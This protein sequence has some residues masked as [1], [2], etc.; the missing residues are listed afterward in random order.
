MLIILFNVFFLFII[1]NHFFYGCIENFSDDKYEEYELS[2]SSNNDILKNNKTSLSTLKSKFKKI[3]NLINNNIK[4]IKQNT[5]NN[6]DS[7][8]ALK[9]DDT[10]TSNACEKYPQA[11]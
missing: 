4:Q 2:I 10:D 11:C 9:G 8:K 5:K 6:N 3:S 1:I 7:S